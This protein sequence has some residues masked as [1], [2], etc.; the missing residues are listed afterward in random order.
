MA[1]PRT[2]CDARRDEARRPSPE[3]RPP[4]R[5]VGRRPAPRCCRCGSVAP[6]P[7]WRCSLGPQESQG[8]PVARPHVLNKPARSAVKVSPPAT[9][10]GVRLHG[11]QLHV[12]VAASA[13]TPS[14]PAELSPQQYA[15]PA[16][17]R[18]QAC[19]F[20]AATVEKVSPP[21]TASGVSLH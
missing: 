20:A 15:A 17:L 3:R 4:P 16:A 9:A 10:T 6:S 21:A 5:P 7:S 14:W 18:P 2:L 11:L 19:R 1:S 12:S 8:P 13:P